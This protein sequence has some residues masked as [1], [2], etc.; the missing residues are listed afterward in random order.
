MYFE[1]GAFKWTSSGWDAGATW[2]DCRRG[3]Q[4]PL[5]WSVL[6]MFWKWDVSPESEPWS[7]LFLSGL[8]F[9]ISG[10]VR[11]CHQLHLKNLEL[12]LHSY[13][14]VFFRS[15]TVPLWAGQYLDSFKGSESECQDKMQM[16]VRVSPVLL[17]MCKTQAI[18]WHLLEG[19]WF[20]L[21]AG[22]WRPTSSPPSPLQLALC[23]WRP[24]GTMRES[25]GTYS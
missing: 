15:R 17:P 3:V 21:S 2:Q 5:D 8:Y 4:C 16:F 13:F 9:K 22:S 24:G 20:P 11:P 14:G 6:G 12:T 18:S 1:G 23:S 19:G 7:F 10:H 25:L